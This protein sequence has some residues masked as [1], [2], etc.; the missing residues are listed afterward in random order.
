M[1]MSHIHKTQ[2]NKNTVHVITFFCR[3][4]DKCTQFSQ[5]QLV[6]YMLLKERKL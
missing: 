3:F 5:K 1:F 4:S 6:Y 2:D